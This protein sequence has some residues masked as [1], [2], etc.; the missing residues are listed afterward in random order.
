MVRSIKV[1]SKIPD[2]KANMTKLTGV[3]HRNK[4]ATVHRGQCIL[5]PVDLN[6]FSYVHASVGSK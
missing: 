6:V 4:L 2:L 5:A 1:V 3:K